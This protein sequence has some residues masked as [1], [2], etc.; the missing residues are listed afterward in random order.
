[1][2]KR[3][4]ARSVA[5]IRASASGDAAAAGRDDGKTAMLAAMRRTTRAPLEAV[6]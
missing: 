4:E 1:M 2:L 5:K 3:T 6:T